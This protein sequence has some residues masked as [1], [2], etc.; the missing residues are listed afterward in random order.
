VTPCLTVGRVL[1]GGMFDIA[2]AAGLLPEGQVVTETVRSDTDAI[3][4][5]FQV[6]ACLHEPHAS[7]VINQGQ[8]SQIP[9]CF[10]VTSST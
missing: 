4:T 1:P 7:F 5:S 2:M 3:D 9:R 10:Q 8:F 6:P